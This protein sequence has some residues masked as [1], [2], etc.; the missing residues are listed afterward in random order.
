MELE[1]VQLSAQHEVWL[2]G[3]F[4]FVGMFQASRYAS[5][6]LT[7]ARVVICSSSGSASDVASTTDL[8]FHSFQFPMTSI[9]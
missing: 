4:F 2:P 9:S 7:H 8:V 3:T 1:D 6:P 5:K